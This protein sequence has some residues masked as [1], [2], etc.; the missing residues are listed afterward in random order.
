MP[1]VVQVFDGHG[2][3]LNREALSCHNHAMFPSALQDLRFALRYF[4]RSPAFTL[5]VI[6]T[7]ALGIGAT[8]SIFSLVDGI[9]LSPLPFPHADR[10]VAIGTLN[11]PPEF[12]P[13]ILRPEAMP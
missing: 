13:S 8:T 3:T 2:G 10:L 9:L 7:L 4:R 5:T 1:F 11:F 6:L 12:L